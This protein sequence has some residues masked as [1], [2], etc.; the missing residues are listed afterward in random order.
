[1]RVELR[2]NGERVITAQTIDPHRGQWSQATL[3]AGDD[4]RGRLVDLTSDGAAGRGHVGAGRGSGWAG[5]RGELLSGVPV[6]AGLPIDAE[7]ILGADHFLASK[8]LLAPK[9]AA[10][11]VGG[12]LEIREADLSLGSAAEA[13]VRVLSIERTPDAVVTL[14]G[15]GRPAR[16][17]EIAARKRAADVLYLDERGLPLV[18]E[19]TAFGVRFERRTP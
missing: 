14:R 12:T 3:F 11:A 18:W 7:V 17:F 15:Q 8:L 19:I 9:L 2:A 10:L 1:L 5:I 6:T 4:G 13:P 16:R